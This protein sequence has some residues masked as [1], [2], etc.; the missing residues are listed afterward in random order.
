MKLKR[1]RWVLRDGQWLKKVETTPRKRVYIISDSMAPIQSMADGQVYDSKSAYYA[2]VKARGMEIVGDEKPTQDEFE[3][4]T[5]A[6]VAEAW[7]MCE[8]G[9]GA[10]QLGDKPAE[11]EDGRTDLLN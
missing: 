10:S 11:W 4:V 6:E 5:E 2:D 1:G 7:D 9:K 8:A 3:A